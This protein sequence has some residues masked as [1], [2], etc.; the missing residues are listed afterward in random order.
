MTQIIPILD[1]DLPKPRGHAPLRR[2]L[3]IRR[4]SSLDATWPEGHVEN[5]HFHGLGRD[6]FT[7]ANGGEPEAIRTDE[8]FVKIA[9]DRTIKAIRSIPERENIEK[10]IGARGG[11]HLRSTLNET[12]PDE[13]RA[14]S[15]LYLL[16]DDLSGA[17]LVS[18][19]ALYSAGLVTI[20]GLDNAQ[21]QE[22]IAQREGV[23]IGFRPGSSA[24][25]I[26]NDSKIGERE[27]TARV[28]PLQNPED[29]AGWHP[30]IQHEETSFRRARRIDVWIDGDIQI[31]TTFQDSAT[32]P[33]G[34]R[35]AVH[36]YTL[37]VSAD[38]DTLVIKTIEA[39]P[40]ILPFPECPNAIEN[41]TKMIGKNLGEMRT[42]VLEEF[43][44]VKGCT[45]LN[46]CMRS[47]AEVPMLVKAL[48]ERL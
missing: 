13:Q 8:L 5:I 46:D 16:I 34:G 30:L 6:I 37:R 27:N 45:H 31:D 43:P 26:P 17:S 9:P 20:P 15:P 41:I 42:A 11:G 40:H 21:R 25:T 19:W 36:E 7:P 14:G 33:D 38:P 3:S 24:L 44:S 29:S 23:C 32:Q 28:T 22:M 4:T 18:G 10:L 12:L 35:E 48:R 47:I 2:P 1:I 39:T